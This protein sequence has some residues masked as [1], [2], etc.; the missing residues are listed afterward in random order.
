MYRERMA[1]LLSTDNL[2]AVLLS[3][4]KRGALLLLCFLL[5]F[6]QTYDTFATIGLD[7]F[8]IPSHNYSQRSWARRKVTRDI[9]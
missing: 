6:G 8:Y 7:G 2:T 4:S 3:T 1:V 9:T 5:L